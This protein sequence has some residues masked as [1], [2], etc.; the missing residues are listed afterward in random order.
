MRGNLVVC[1][2]VVCALLACKKSEEQTA[3]TPTPEPPKP[4]APPPEPEV[5]VEDFKGTYTT[6][7]GTAKCTQGGKNVNC[8][9]AG[10]SGSLDCKIVDEKSLECDWDEPGL[11]GKAKLTKKDDGS[12]RGTWG[13]NSSATNG[14]AWI[15]K[16]KE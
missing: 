16:P 3:P 6:T 15:F 1:A 12:L 4:A 11:S 10:K 8:L 7:W 14:G 2:A 5:K 13:N 9:Y